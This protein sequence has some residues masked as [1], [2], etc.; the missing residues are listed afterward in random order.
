MK[1]YNARRIIREE[2]SVDALSIAIGVF[3]G[4]LLNGRV[5]SFITLPV[6]LAYVPIINGIGGNVLSVFGSRLG[7][8]LHLGYVRGFDRET[9]KSMALFV[10]IAIITFSIAALVLYVSNHFSGESMSFRIAFIPVLAGVMLVGSL[11]PLT[12]LL[13]LVAYRL[14]LDPDNVVISLMTT[15]ADF[16][17]IVFLLLS[18][19]LMGV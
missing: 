8:A 2:L 19:R 18:M 1:Y 10:L 7:S 11:L 12:L 4:L 9:S 15:L 13:G 5:E 14:G 3:G 17:G 16:S 6:L